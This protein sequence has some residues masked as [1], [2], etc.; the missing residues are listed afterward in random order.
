MSLFWFERTSDTI[1]AHL[2]WLAAPELNRLAAFRFPKR[3][4]DWLLGRWTAKCAIACLTDGQLEF[5]EIE[6]RAA[7]SGAPTV[8]IRG[9]PAPFS[10]SLSHRAGVACCAISTDAIDLGC[11][12]ERVEDRSPAFISDYFTDEE[13]ALVSSRER[14][15]ALAW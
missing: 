10:I 6:I 8:R 15:S 3:R 9:D 5:A 14:R 2:D 7:P 13:S 12:L 11:D 1:P 4:A